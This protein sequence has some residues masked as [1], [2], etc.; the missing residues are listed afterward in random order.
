MKILVLA[1]CLLT[2]VVYGFNRES[3]ENYY[4]TLKECANTL[5]TCGNEPNDVMLRI[6]AIQCVLTKYGII[7]K[8]AILNLAQGL[9]YCE[10]WINDPIEVNMCM[11]IINECINKVY[12]LKIKEIPQAV[13]ECFVKEGV[14]GFITKSR[15]YALLKKEKIIL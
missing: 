3:L 11:K 10:D 2:T 14:M 12:Q 4:S 1:M 8:F 13:I 9:Q 6:D 7:N 5:P 15:K